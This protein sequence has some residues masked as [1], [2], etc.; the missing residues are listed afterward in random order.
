MTG[1]LVLSRRKGEAVIIEV[2]GG[3]TICVTV[4]ELHRSSCKLLFDA[5]GVVVARA[6]LHDPLPEPEVIRLRRLAL[7]FREDRS[8]EQQKADGDHPNPFGKGRAVVVPGVDLTGMT[9]DERDRAMARWL[10]SKDEL[11]QVDDE[12]RRPVSDGM[13]ERCICCGGGELV[14]RPVL[15]PELA[16]EWELLPAE[17]AHIERQQGLTCVACGSNLRTMALAEAVMRHF[18]TNRDVSFREWAAR[19]PYRKLSRVV[20]VNAAGQL[21][22]FFAGWSDH[23]VASYPEVDMMS[24]PFRSGVLDVVLHSDVLEHV[25]DPLQGLRECRRVLRSGGACIFTVPLLSGRLTRRRAGMPAS[26]HGSPSAERCL[27]ETEYGADVWTE[28]LAAGFSECRVVSV[29]SAAVAWI[30]LP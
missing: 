20:E 14:Q 26:Y 16:G 1:R 7:A 30:A 5:P 10:F 25:P 28:V 23:Q 3:P 6:E 8:I 12:E 21:T 27:V 17:Y 15:W 9:S 2:P 4:G 22:G 19:T 18:Q 29:D 13:I 24:L 11:P